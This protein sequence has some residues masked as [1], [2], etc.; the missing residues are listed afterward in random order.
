MLSCLTVLPTVTNL[1]PKHASASEQPF[2]A[3]VSPSS[4][5]ML[6]PTCFT[7]TPLFVFQVAMDIFV[8]I[9]ERRER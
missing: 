4:A 8:R 3:C 6:R 7:W 5:E 9:T 2:P 1:L